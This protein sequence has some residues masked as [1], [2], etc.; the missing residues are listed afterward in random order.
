MLFAPPPPISFSGDVAPIFAMHCN[1]CH[2]D[3]G[4]LDLRSYRAAMTGGNLGK[5]IIAG[6]AER[7]LLIHFVD[8]RRGQARLMPVGGRPLSGAQ[9]ETL[10]RWI[11]AGAIED[12]PANASREKRRIDAVPIAADRPIRIT[13]TVPVQ[14][15]L[16]V[17]VSDPTTGAILWTEVAALK[18]PKE[19]NDAAEPGQPLHWVVRAAPG[20]P[21][22]V[23]VQ[24][25]IEHAATKSFDIAFSV[26]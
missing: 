13:C 8:G 25:S 3:V 12:N 10:R 21:A 2:G 16:T 19:Q 9:I 11:D 15:Y 6:D 22:A 18:S 24:L 1:G 26:R 20:W 7:S 5:V 17:S 4:G 14:A 23:D